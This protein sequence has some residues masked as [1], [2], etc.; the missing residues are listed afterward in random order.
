MH[1]MNRLQREQEITNSVYP[2]KRQ[3]QERNDSH[4]FYIQSHTGIL[5]RRRFIRTRRLLST[6]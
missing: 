4:D 2:I 6:A 5:Y 1:E 3:Q